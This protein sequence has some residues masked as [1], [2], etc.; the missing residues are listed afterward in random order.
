MC[1]VVFDIDVYHQL[2]LT[3]VCT[4]TNTTNT[5]KHI[6]THIHAYTRYHRYEPIYFD[7]PKTVSTGA[8]TGKTTK[9]ALTAKEKDS[10]GVRLEQKSIIN[11]ENAEITSLVMFHSFLDVLAVSDGHVSDLVIYLKESAFL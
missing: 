3:P 7:P 4:Y 1:S 11:I 5:Y 6:G 10:K 8:T 2:T 9:E